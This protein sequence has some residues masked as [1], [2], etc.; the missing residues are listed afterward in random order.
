VKSPI[1]RFA[2][3]VILTSLY[4]L[5]PNAVRAA[6]P[7]NSANYVLH[8]G[9]QLAI[10]VYGE[11]TLT[12]NTTVLPDGTINYP[13]VGKVT[14]GNRT[15]DAATRELAAELEQYVRKPMVSI[16]VIQL[17]TYDV[18]VL[19]D[20]KTPGKYPLPSTARVTD[21]IAAAGGL[22]AVN[23]EY[24]V[25][26]VSIN[27]GPPV[28]VSLQKLMRDGDVDEN[29]PLGEET[30]VYV[31]GP[32]PMQVQVVGNVD[33]PGAVQVHVGDRLATAVAVAGTTA[34][35]QADLSH[36]RVTH[37]DPDGSVHVKEYNL[38]NALRG[39][40]M[41][42]DPVLAKDDVIYVP[43]AH[44]GGVISGF[45]QG[46]LLLLSRLTIPI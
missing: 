35:S 27:N 16:A 26:R 46:I 5:V 3:L 12:Q 11:P 44:Q 4:A 24:P 15:V 23:G 22:D 1:L 17:G 9:D 6:V 30:I 19:G 42:S 38:Y 25:A 13:L 7:A 31:P 40:D 2:L 29:L 14:V 18:L 36:I 10:T 8:P 41:S 37:V 34:S 20:V 21:A 33:K 43:Q 39:G 32:T 45:A 28:T